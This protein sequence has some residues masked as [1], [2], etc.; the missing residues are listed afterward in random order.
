MRPVLPLLIAALC[1]ASPAV[2]QQPPHNPEPFGLWLEEFKRDALAQGISQQTVDSAFTNT[3][4]PI[5]R[6][7]ELDRRQP[8]ST[9]TFD[10]YLENV[11]TDQRVAQGRRLLAENR[12]LLERV[13]KRYGVQPAFIVALWGVETS[14]GANTGK[15]VLV[16]SLATLAYDGRR[17]D[18]FRGELIKALKIADQEQIAPTELKGSWAGAMGQCQFMP[19]S[20]LEYA[21]DEDGDGHRDIWNTRA[22]VFAS[23]ANYL[24]S[25][26]WKGDEAWGRAV[27]V[28]EGLDKS[29]ADI[30]QT[31]TLAEW[32]ALGVRKSGGGEL[33]DKDIKASLIFVGEGEDAQPF[34]VYG[35]YKVL[36]KWNRSRFFATAVSMLADRIGK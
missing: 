25:S 14:F 28:P 6:V 5:A 9:M 26:G 34:I 35:N 18:Y 20:F 22:D 16:D 33:P 21:V 4:A 3:Q 36:L 13:S 32:R 1:C 12:D 23:I 31:K 10:T 24:S 7:I 2:A 8:E 11:V 17:S 30:K 19:T 15:F 27:V 29:L